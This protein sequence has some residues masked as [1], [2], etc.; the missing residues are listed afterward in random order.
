MMTTRLACH[1]PTREYVLRR[2]GDGKT[3][4]EAQRCIK[5]HLARRIWRLLDHGPQVLPAA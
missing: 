4:R 1:S 3:Q 2:I 5:R